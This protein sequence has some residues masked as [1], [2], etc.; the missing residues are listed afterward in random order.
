M[1]TRARGGARGETKGGET[2]SGGN[3]RSFGARARR[4]TRIRLRLCAP[5]IAIARER[6]REK[7]GCKGVRAGFPGSRR[8]LEGAIDHTRKAAAAA[9]ARTHRRTR[10]HNIAD[11]LS[12]LL[13]VPAKAHPPISGV[14]EKLVFEKGRGAGQ[15][16]KTRRR[17]ACRNAALRR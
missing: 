5:R 1:A 7:G 3:Y 11:L 12:N 2:S 6:A 9:L 14:K 13:L 15:L 16:A 8:G 17:V 4:P 10:I